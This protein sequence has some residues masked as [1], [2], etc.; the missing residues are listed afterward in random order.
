ML[1]PI[2]LRA[3]CCHRF[4]R[5]EE[6]LKVVASKPKACRSALAHALRLTPSVTN[7]HLPTL[8][9]VLVEAG[10]PTDRGGP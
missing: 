7:E 3:A 9:K 5:Q 4:S 1:R 10:Q 6:C 2:K 8:Y